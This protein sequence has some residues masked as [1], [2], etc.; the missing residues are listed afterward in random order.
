ME[1][2]I[3]QGG[4]KL[5][6]ELKIQGSKNSVLPILAATVLT[7]EPC[8]LHHCPN[9]RDVE[10]AISILRHLGCRVQRQGDTITVEGSVQRSD[11]P[12]DLMREMRSSVIF[13]GAILSR[14]G[15]AKMSFPG[16]CELGPRP[17]DLHIAGLRKLGAELDDQGGSLEGRAS[18]LR[19]CHVQ[20]S[21]PSVGATENLMLAAACSEGVT[22]IGNCAKEPEIEDLQAF[23]CSMGARITGAGSSTIRIEGVARL[24]GTEYTVMPDRIVAATYLASVAS[25]G[26]HALLTHVS[27]GH[28]ESITELLQESGCTLKQEADRIA[29]WRD[30]PLH[31]LRMVRTMPYPGFPTDAQSILMA[32]MITAQG[33]SVFVENI[34]ENRYKQVGELT[35]M[36]A[37][38][39]VN[40]RTAVVTGVPH[41]HGAQVQCTDLR[42]GA[43][44]AV[45]ALA[46]EGTTEITKISHIQRG[47]DNLEGCLR[48]LGAD[49]CRQE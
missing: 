16:G 25:A 32:C 44:L 39:R 31:S 9:L 7:D 13:L 11:I 42:G 40:G 26:G 49:V 6:G 38:I 34:F 28:L 12:L 37:D 30:G 4:R 1:K 2:I 33:T 10:S 48:R 18:H 19:G 27:P 24:H 8:V 15:Q 47:Y 17:V 3:I 43:A 14:C 45:A 36:G 22:T 41:L 35:M 21:F 29:I 46:A 20:L 5:E 23:L